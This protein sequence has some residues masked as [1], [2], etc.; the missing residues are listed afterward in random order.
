MIAGSERPGS[1]IAPA[2]LKQEMRRLF[3]KL[4]EPGHSA[5]RIG[6]GR[7]GVF[8]ERQ[9]GERPHLVIDERIVELL[10][11]RDL[12][13]GGSAAAESWRLSPQG[14]AFWQRELAGETPFLVQHQARSIQKRALDDGTVATV[15]VNDTESPLAWLHKRKGPDGNA[16][17][18]ERQFRAGERLR[19]DFERAQ[20]GNRVTMDWNPAATPAGGKRGSSDRTR[21]SDS[22]VAA[23][24]KFEDAVEAVG[25][26]L[27]DL[28]IDVC[29]YLRGLEQVEQA[30]GWPKRSAKVVLDIALERLADHYGL[31]R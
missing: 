11:R 9:R 1:R 30:Q 24:R 20:L 21:L 27:S 3:R 19:S 16:Y 2:E 7:V 10:A 25:P 15:T 6:P 22:A 17:I 14:H 5:R 26:R 31:P 12:L 28:L 23:R 18:D 29:C 4:A 13:E 8:S